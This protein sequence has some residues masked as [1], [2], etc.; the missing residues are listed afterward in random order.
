M[1]LVFT[2]LLGLTI[3]L[4][5]SD[6]HFCGECKT[7]TELEDPNS[8]CIA[9]GNT[10]CTT[11]WH[12][13]IQPQ[14]ARPPVLAQQE[15]SWCIEG[16]TGNEPAKIRKTLN[17]IAFWLPELHGYTID[18]IEKYP[19]NKQTYN[20]K[21]KR[22]SQPVPDTD[23]VWVIGFVLDQRYS[24]GLGLMPGMLTRALTLVHDLNPQAIPGY[25]VRLPTVGTPILQ[26]NDVRWNEDRIWNNYFVQRNHG[27]VYATKVILGTVNNEAK[28]WHK[29]ADCG[30]F[31][32]YAF[33][34]QTSFEEK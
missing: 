11:R 14:P 2:L 15:I 16:F 20:L 8:A 4:T 18:R 33:I 3:E 23:T 29:I 19:H 27:R 28:T 12:F 26:P 10:W 24:I 13:E 7:E 32:K 30:W 1:I 5:F 17:S 22:Y 6:Y 21:L 9:C 31:Y 34:I 25:I